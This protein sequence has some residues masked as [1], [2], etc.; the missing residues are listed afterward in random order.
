ME[1]APDRQEVLSMCEEWMWHRRREAEAAS[2]LWDEFERTPPVSEPER[3][4][5]RDVTLEER[6]RTPTAPAT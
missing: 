3:V 1:G 6:E 5:E 4:D 2:R